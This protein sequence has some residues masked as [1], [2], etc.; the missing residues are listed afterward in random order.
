MIPES[1]PARSMVEND[2]EVVEKTRVNE[3]G[4]LMAVRSQPPWGHVW[5]DDD[6]HREMIL[7]YMLLEELKKPE[8]HQTVG[9]LSQSLTRETLN[10]TRI[11]AAASWLI[12]R[13]GTMIKRPDRNINSALVKIRAYLNCELKPTQDAEWVQ[14]YDDQDYPKLLEIVELARLDRNVIEGAVKPKTAAKEEAAGELARLRRFEDEDGDNVMVNPSQSD[15]STSTLVRTQIDD[16][17]EQLE[18][19]YSTFLRE[20]S[21]MAKRLAGMDPGDPEYAD[22]KAAHERDQSNMTKFSSSLN[23]AKEVQKQTEIL[24]RQKNETARKSVEL[25]LEH[26]ERTIE[27]I[28]FKDPKVHNEHGVAKFVNEGDFVTEERTGDVYV[29]TIVTPLNPETRK[30]VSYNDMLNPQH[31]CLS[32]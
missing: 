5:V 4:K 3:D 16:N 2:H 20:I 1:H 13:F 21:K 8:H 10:T 29:V 22:L 14:T 24:L 6:M 31:P 17:V 12:K 32:I 27:T 7:W 15:R 23:H 30:T 28:A 11:E 9:E 19:E 26:D 18:R 25:N